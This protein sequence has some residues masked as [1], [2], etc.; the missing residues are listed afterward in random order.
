MKYL[1]KGWGIK[2]RDIQKLYG[3]FKS[4]AKTRLTRNFIFDYY[5]D[6]FIEAV[7][8]D[9]NYTRHYFD[10][11]ILGN[12]ISYDKLSKNLSYKYIT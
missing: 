11:E 7:K 10:I 1:R 8:N 2:K 3:Y 6:K 12:L 4:N 5:T 9:D